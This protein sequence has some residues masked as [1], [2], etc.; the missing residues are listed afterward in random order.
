MFSTVNFVC[1]R[2]LKNWLDGQDQSERGL[3]GQ[4]Q[5]ERCLEKIG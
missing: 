3:D 1:A 2:E 4:D 5:S